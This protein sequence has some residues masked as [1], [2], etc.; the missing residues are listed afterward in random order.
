V[1]RVMNS[2]PLRPVV[3]NAFLAMKI[4]WGALKRAMGRG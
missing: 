2:P 4:V 3:K 1:V